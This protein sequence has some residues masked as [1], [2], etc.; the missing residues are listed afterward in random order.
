MNYITTAK[1]LPSTRSAK[2]KTESIQGIN[3]YLQGKSQHQ[4]TKTDNNRN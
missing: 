2:E 3:K 4:R 1:S